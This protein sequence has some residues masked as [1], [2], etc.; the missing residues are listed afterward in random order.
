MINY[1]EYDINKLS[2]D[3][4]RQKSPAYKNVQ[5]YTNLN[6]FVHLTLTTPCLYVPFGISTYKN[7]SD[8]KS[9]TVSLSPL[10]KKRKP[11]LDFLKKL[12]KMIEN[13]IKNK[14]DNG[15]NFTYKT[16]IEKHSTGKWPLR[17]K[18]NLP[19][20]KNNNNIEE[21]AFTIYN[22]KREPVN[23]DSIKAGSRVAII[24][25]LIDIWIS[26]DKHEFGCNWDVIQIKLYPSIINQD[27]MFIDEV[28]NDSTIELVT[29]PSID[30]KIE[31]STECPHCSHK[32]QFNINITINNQN[33]SGY[34]THRIPYISSVPHSSSSAPTIPIAPIAPTN[35]SNNEV[36]GNR[37]VPNLR[38]ILDMKKKLKSIH[39][40]KSKNNDKK[41]KTKTKTKTKK[42]S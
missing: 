28:E 7:N 42:T 14:L 32:I 38:D 11:F 34:P 2:F 5:V 39:Q 26:E 33:Q 36:V 8:M 21:F 3:I 22:A 37:F 10:D 30:T 16:M 13:K 19:K 12:D 27:Y 20:V 23:I 17:I 6:K 18:L 15:D 4:I 29:K 41:T 24:I 9:L 40:N 35:E 31:C 1:A 25:E